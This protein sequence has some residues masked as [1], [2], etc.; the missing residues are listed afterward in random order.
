MTTQPHVVALASGRRTA[1]PGGGRATA[2]DKQPVESFEVREPGPKRGG[3]G[4]GVVGDEIGNPKHH[5]GSLQAV[6]AYP[7]EDQQFWQERIGRPIRPG[8]F[9]ENITTV[10]VEMTHA[11]V[12]EVWRLGDVVLRVEGPRIPCRTF[13]AHM[14]EPGWVRR[15]TQ[16]GRTGAYLSVVTPG[17][18]HTGAE[19]V[20]ERPEHEIDLLLLFRALSGDLVAARRVVDADVVHPDVRDE[21]LDTL[22]RRGA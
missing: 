1:P 11:L 19:V 4:S 6:Y 20:V 21:L 13:A 3:L 9:G 18:V 8:G 17:V 14:G 10:G 16:E 5:G 15:F 12:G 22:Q 2:I 7:R